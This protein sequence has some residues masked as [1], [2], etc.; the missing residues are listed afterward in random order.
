MK[1][2]TFLGKGKYTSTLYFWKGQ[3]HTTQYSP[4]ASCVFLKPEN[5]VVFLTEDAYA[6]FEEFKSELSPEI[7]IQ[8]VPIP[9]GKNEQELW[10]I[11]DQISAQVKPGEDV[12]FDITNG[13][14]SF[15]LVGL[16]SA[17]FL[18]F[19]LGIHL[20]AILYGAF[21]VRDTSVTPNRTPMFDLTPMVKLLEWSGAAD[22]FNQ[23][24]DAR[25]LAALINN[26][27]KELVINGRNDPEI[28]NLASSL[29]SLTNILNNI[30]QSLRLIRPE[31]TMKHTASLAEAIQKSKP[32]LA[33]SAGTMPFSLL[34]EKIQ[35]G[36]AD[37]GMEN[38]GETMS[39]EMLDRQRWIIKWYVDREHW[40]QAITLSREWLINYV[41]AYL[42]L[43]TFIELKVRSEIEDLI[44]A[45]VYNKRVSKNLHTEYLTPASLAKVPCSEEVLNIWSSLVEARN[46]IDHAGMR[47]NPC[48]P[49]DLIKVIKKLFDRIN[50]LPVKSS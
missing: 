47:P 48:K 35:G 27:R 40:V 45:E 2:L 9:L 39:F 32:A 38:P 12:A 22:R 23:T 41:I 19:G 8:A 4:A 14:R 28:N 36:F 34:L 25:H 33:R 37:L 31:Y 17:A 13:L 5:L 46:D 44:N 7:K 20:S 24:G 10:Q 6:N 18:Q 1:L 16:L 30:S 29:G 49:E 26:Q 43:E 11:F 50:L 42:D 3:E 21:D 15:P